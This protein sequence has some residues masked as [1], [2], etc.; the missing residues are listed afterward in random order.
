MTDYGHSFRT[1]PYKEIKEEQNW[2]Y[3]S[4]TL[5]G[6]QLIAMQDT[7]KHVELIPNP[8]SK[9]E[10]DLVQEKKN[11]EHRKEYQERI[12]KISFE[13]KTIT[14]DKTKELKIF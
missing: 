4:K 2:K 5:I 14:E 13:K 11:P 3:Q 12:E 8:L 9:E 10:H 1:A 7:P 6:G